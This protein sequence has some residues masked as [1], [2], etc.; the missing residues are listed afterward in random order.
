[1][2]HVW[3]L[4]IWV[5]GNGGYIVVPDIATW[6]ECQ[7]LGHVLLK[8]NHDD[9]DPIACHEYVTNVDRSLNHSNE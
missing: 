9:G 1:M 7:R 8:E 5:Y 6:G 3:L 4:T 2:I